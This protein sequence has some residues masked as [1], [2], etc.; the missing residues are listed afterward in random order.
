MATDMLCKFFRCL[1]NAQSN[2]LCLYESKFNLKIT[3]N[4]VEIN[5][6]F[7]NDQVCRSR[8]SLVLIAKL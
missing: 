2:K 1:H 5:A 4:Q 8:A 6:T 7:E 3:R